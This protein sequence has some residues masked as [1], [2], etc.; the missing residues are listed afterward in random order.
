MQHPDDSRQA[1]QFSRLFLPFLLLPFPR[2]LIIK[3]KGL[4]PD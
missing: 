1:I 4:V 3:W 2:L